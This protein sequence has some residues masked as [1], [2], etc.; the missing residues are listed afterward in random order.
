M[1]M[2]MVVSIFPSFSTPFRCSAT[3]PRATTAP[4]FLRSEL[5]E[6]FGILSVDRLARFFVSALPEFRTP[7]IPG[8]RNAIASSEDPNV[9]TISLKQFRAC[10]R[11]PSL[12]SARP[13]AIK[14]LVTSFRVTVSIVTFNDFSV[15]AEIALNMLP[16]TLIFSSVSFSPSLA[17]VD[18]L[19]WLS[20]RFM[21]NVLSCFGCRSAGLIFLGADF[22]LPPVFGL[23]K[24]A[25]ESASFFA[26][27]FFGRPVEM[28]FFFGANATGF[29]EGNAVGRDG[30]EE[31]LCD[32]LLSITYES[33]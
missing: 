18:V 12:Q 24:P 15:I 11:T 27:F 19:N 1:S 13:Y 14:K 31:V 25:I 8:R 4:C 7:S 5:C 30:M 28:G 9:A 33:I 16:L 20:K 26:V 22:F 17:L 32:E 23:P 2:S 29:L 3:E 6:S 21:S 10:P